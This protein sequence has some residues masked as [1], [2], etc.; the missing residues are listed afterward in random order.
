MYRK[1]LPGAEYGSLAEI[2][3]IN[4]RSDCG[5]RSSQRRRCTCCKLV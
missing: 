4:R 2:Q 5:T 1:F 3:D